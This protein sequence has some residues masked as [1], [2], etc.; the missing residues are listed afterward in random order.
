MMTT[1]TTMTTIEERAAVPLS[2]SG[3][4]ELAR[5]HENE[6]V[7]SV[8]LARDSSDPG[9]RGAWRLRLQDGLETIRDCIEREVPT[10]L[11]AFDK[12]VGYMS[13]GL[14]D[15]GRVLPSEGWAAFVTEHGVLHAER[16]AFR[17]LEVVRWRQC[18][19]AA[20]YLRAL[21]ARRPVVLAVLTRMHATLYRYLDGELGPG[22]E[23]HADRPPAESADVGVSKRASVASGVRGVTRTDYT[24]RAVEENAKRLRKRVV[25]ALEEMA[26]D[27]GGVVL[28]GTGRAISAVKKALGPRLEGRVLEAPELSFDSTPPELLGRVAAAAS[29]LTRGRQSSLLD[30]CADAGDRASRGWNA[31]YR[32]LAVGAVDTLLVARELIESSPDDAERLVRLALAQGADVEELGEDLGERLMR[33]SEGIAARL[34]FRM[35]S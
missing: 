19:Y 14:E 7:L 8:Y 21:K 11:S 18:V 28:G 32:A 4:A 31:T 33:E 6:M 25:Q 12:A 30:G 16:L 23:L 20:P 13:G 3:L 22:V 5:A 9:G 10:D 15:Y 27:D 17:P 26:G 2:R 24:E 29:T 34:R 1:M 35:L